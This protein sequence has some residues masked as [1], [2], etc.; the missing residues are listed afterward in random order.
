[1]KSLC[2]YS[3]LGLV[4]CT[5]TENISTPASEAAFKNMPDRW[6]VTCVD[7]AGAMSV[8]IFWDLKS[9]NEETG[10]MEL[11]VT[12]RDG[13]KGKASAR[14]LNNKIRISWS[15]RVCSSKITIIFCRY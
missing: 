8:P 5:P 14:I 1:M 4:C 12:D 7:G 2:S 10:Q 11:V 15:I 3:I 9:F 6:R 13:I